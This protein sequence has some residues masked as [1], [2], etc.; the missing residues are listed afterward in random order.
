MISTDLHDDMSNVDNEQLAERVEC[1]EIIR[2][3]NEYGVTQRQLLIM[4]NM[5]A[6]ELENRTYML[7]L[8]DITSDFLNNVSH[9]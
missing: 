5:L 3:I 9:G 6:L 7:Q 4:I 8:V 2:K 1:R